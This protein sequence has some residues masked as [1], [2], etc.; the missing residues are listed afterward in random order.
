MKAL[1]TGATG[2]VGGLLAARLREEGDTV[3]ALVRSPDRAR[4]LVRLGV[5]TVA[6]DLA[7]RPALATAATGCDIVYHLAGAIAA[8][9]EAEF[10]TVNETGTQAVADAA[11]A[12]GI[13]RF[14]LVSSLAAAGPS[15]PGVPLR[16]DEPPRP[17]SQY[18]R[19]KLAGEAVVRRS[20]LAWSILR[21]PAVYGPGD[22]EMFRIF[23]AVATFG[24]APVF[25]A[26]GQRLSLVYGPD[27]AEALTA[28]GRSP[29]AI[30]QTWYPAHPEVHTS[31]SL[32][33][34]V[35]QAAGRRARVLSIPFPVGR[36]L[37]WATDLA[38]RM[39]GRPTVLT[40]DKANELFQPAWLCDPSPLTQATGW[41]AQHDLERGAKATLDW[42]RQAGWL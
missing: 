17:V 27:L 5:V 40:R 10:L 2:F 22:R 18:G 7:D 9:S 30:G 12:A 37:L 15:E 1:V 4:D 20:S 24:I 26:G 31:R 8:R 36:G 6:G 29:G 42:Y 23:K 14:V 25:G 41:K 16:G 34:A 38:A 35:A 32:I 33:D 11:T 13:E 39:T 3:V 19:S 21:P 28:V